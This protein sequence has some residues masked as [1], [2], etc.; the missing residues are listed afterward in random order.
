L[1]DEVLKPVDVGLDLLGLFL[2]G[3]NKFILHLHFEQR[4]SLFILEIIIKVSSVRGGVIHDK[5]FLDLA[6]EF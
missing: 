1:F 3:V 4:L 5:G 6:V 2:K